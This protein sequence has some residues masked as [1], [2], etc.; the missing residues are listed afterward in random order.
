M[1]KRT[2]QV[3]Y[4]I[5]QMLDAVLA[6]L[7]FTVA[8]FARHALTLWWPEVFPVTYEF[9]QVAWLYILLVPLW[10]F[11]FDFSNFYQHKTVR[12]PATIF[13]MLIRA[14]VISIMI[15][16][17][18]LYILKIKHVPRVLIFLCGFFDVVFMMGK[19]WLM[20]RLEPVWSF[21]PNLLLV[22]RAG[23]FADL[24]QRF[25]RIPRW[26]P[27]VLGLLV[28]V[29]VAKDVAVEDLKQET[30]TLGDVPYLGTVDDLPTVLHR[31]TVD[32]VVLNPGQENFAE[33]QRAISICETEGV[34]TWLIAKF[35]KTSVAR[36]Q[37]DEFQGLPM[38]IFSSTPTVSWALFLKRVIDIVGSLLLL[39]VMSPVMIAAT[40]AIKLG[41]PGP[42][43][44]TQ[45]RCTLHGRTFSMYKFRTMVSEAENLRDELTA[46]N[47]MSGP[48]FKVKNDPRVTR[49]GAFLRRHSLDELPQLFNVLKGDM[50]L[51]GPRPPIPEEVAKYENWQRRRLSMRSGIT[52]L[53]QVS[54]R[55]QIDFDEWMRLDLKY[56]DEWSLLLDLRI[57][58]KSVAVVFVGTGY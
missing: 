11:V 58:V 13:Q 20:Y 47:E 43:I 41:S 42:V 44:F 39:L 57:L 33:V 25:A 19:E 17:F 5:E 15:A 32:H 6:A 52:G 24:N 9:S 7:A 37:V 56:I 23:E 34:E 28:P 4:Q 2:S 38:V 51:V 8:F 53:W 45:R 27:K 22:G 49:V 3:R 26:N 54:G 46:R 50:S 40:I 55:N 29:S 48:V 12:T 14:N 35:F 21:S 10:V 18:I 1:L 16:F 36:A 31:H 30:A